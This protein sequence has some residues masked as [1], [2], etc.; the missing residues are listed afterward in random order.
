MQSQVLFSVHTYFGRKSQIYDSRSKTLLSVNF[1]KIF[2]I[3]MASNREPLSLDLAFALATVDDGLYPV[4]HSCNLGVNTN[5]TTTLGM[6]GIIRINHTAIFVFF[7]DS[8]RDNTN[9]LPFFHFFIVPR[10]WSCKE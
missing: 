1:L 4:Q 10:K 3:I 9:E 8:M 2:L 5:F 7:H 6:F